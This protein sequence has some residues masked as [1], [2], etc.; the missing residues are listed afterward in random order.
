MMILM[1]VILDIVEYNKIKDITLYKKT[2]NSKYFKYGWK[3]K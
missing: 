3:K 1:I 2:L